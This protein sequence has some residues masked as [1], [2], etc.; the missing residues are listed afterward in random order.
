MAK[1][2]EPEICQE[3]VMT[4]LTNIKH[5]LDQCNMELIGQTQSSISILLPSIEILDNCLKEYVYLQQNYLFKSIDNQLIRYKD[6]IYDQKLYQQLSAYH[7][8]TTQQ[9]VIQQLIHLRQVQLQVYEEMIMLKERILHQLLPPN[10]DYVEQYIAQD[11]YWPSIADHTLVEMKNT[12]R[13]ILQQGKRALLNVYMYA[14]R[15]KINNYEQQYQQALNEIEL[16]F[17][18]NNIM[19]N[20]LTLFH[21]V[22][23]YMTHR[24]DRIKQEIH[25]KIIY[26]RQIIARHRQRSSLAKKMISVSPQVTVDALHHILN[27]DDLAY[28]SRGKIDCC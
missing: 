18:C 14:Y 22:K 17:T 12:R 11:F 26:F 4:Q 7:L 16:N 21:A 2:N 1:T 13:K 5:Q 8:T 24:T 19:I 23:A 10:F 15:F 27:T 9:Q 6:D 28:L 3:F 20:G 25:D